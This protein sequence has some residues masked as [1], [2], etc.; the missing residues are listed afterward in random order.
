M[1][2][3]V[4]VDTPSARGSRN[5]GDHGGVVEKMGYAHPL[6][7]LLYLSPK[8]KKEISMEIYSTSGTLCRWGLGLWG[9]C[10]RADWGTS[11]KSTT[12]Q[13]KPGLI[14]MRRSFQLAFF[15]G[16]WWS[17][18]KELEFLLP[19]FTFKWEKNPQAQELHSVDYNR[20]GTST[21]CSTWTHQSL[22]ILWIYVPYSIGGRALAVLIIS[23][24][25]F[26]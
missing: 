25:G 1:K 10:E 24:A 17:S 11:R 5:S 19:S 18:W 23:I 12:L 14:H 8:G 13:S 6:F 16:Y 15:Q 21:T 20:S 4:N 26:P 2:C 7:P 3:D 9:V 22:Y